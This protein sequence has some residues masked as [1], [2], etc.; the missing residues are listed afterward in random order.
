MLCMKEFAMKENPDQTCS[1]GITTLRI[2]ESTG[3][4]NWLYRLTI[5]EVILA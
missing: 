1:G 5:G 4:Q 2:E 3:F